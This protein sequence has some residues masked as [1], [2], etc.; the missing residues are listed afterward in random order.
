M[1]ETSNHNEN[2]NCA[3][4]VL[5]V[6]TPEMEQFAA[7]YGLFIVSVGQKYINMLSPYYTTES[8]ME[9]FKREYW[10]KKWY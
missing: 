8:A 7:E 5:A 4:R 1:A 10:G 2:G 6:V 9:I 3:N